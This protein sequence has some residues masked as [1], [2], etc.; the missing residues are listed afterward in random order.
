[1]T[2]IQTFTGKAFR[3]SAIEVDLDDIAHHLAMRCR[4]NGACTQFY[5]VAE[6]SVR[7][8]RMP[9]SVNV[10]RWCLFHDAAK[11]Y[12]PDVPR[13]FKPM[14]MVWLN[15][16]SMSF[17][18]VEDKILEIV[19]HKFG[20]SWPMPKEVKDLDNRFLVTEKRDLM[21]KEPESWGPMSTPFN[22]KIEPWTWELAERLFHKRHKE[23]FD[24]H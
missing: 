2:W 24:A 1:M 16:H 12:L 13:P 7:M 11:A 18:H 21:T 8:S 9:N 20:L 14:L 5:S 19:A 22:F 23:L 6:H 15:G 4:F 10:Q 3:L 17:N